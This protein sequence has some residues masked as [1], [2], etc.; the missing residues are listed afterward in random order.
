MGQTMLGILLQLHVRMPMHDSNY[1]ALGS[2]YWLYDWFAIRLGYRTKSDIGDGLH[3][4][5]GFAYRDLGIDYA[6]VPYGDLG[7]SH[8]VS[9]YFIFGSPRKAFSD[10]I[11]EEQI[12]IHLA[13]GERYYQDGAL[14]AAKEE[15]IKVLELDQTNKEAKQG[16]DR[17]VNVIYM[18]GLDLYESG[19]YKEALIQWEKVLE[20]Q[21]NHAGADKYLKLTKKKI[22]EEKRLSQE[23]L[24]KKKEEEEKRRRRRREL[25]PIK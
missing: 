21:P 15:F 20:L 13:Q 5:L 10:V 14:I 1:I 9:L 12:A 6:F 24:R 2:E 3:Y 7:S 16:I 8:R 19:K 23:E 25:I 17:I 11:R 22:E 4:G 18:Q